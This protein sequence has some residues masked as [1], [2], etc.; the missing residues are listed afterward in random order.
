MPNAVMLLGNHE[1]MML[2]Y[3]SHD[4]TDI[5]RHRWNRNGNSP[6]LDAYFKLEAK[7]QQ[8]ILDYLKSL[9]THLEIEAGSKRFYLVH[10]F[11][12]ENIHDEVWSRPELDTPNPMP[13]YQ[14]VIGHT[15]VLNLVKPAEEQLE[16]A[17]DLERRG[18]HLKIIH[19]SG[20]INIDCGCGHGMPIKALACIRLED[21]VEYY[22]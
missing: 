8:G 12:G 3:L 1:Y 14:V 7:E 22:K 10:G 6:T 13:G 2:Q 9:P 19:A 11:P 18:D 21:M 5:D 20:F 4:A 17:A 16:Y 15:P